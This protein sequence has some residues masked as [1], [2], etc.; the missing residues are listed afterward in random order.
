MCLPF[1]ARG[2]GS[3]G[4]SCFVFGDYIPSKLLALKPLVRSV[5]NDR[6]TNRTKADDTKNGKTQY[7]EKF[8]SSSEFS[9]RSFHLT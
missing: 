2:R 5:P 7:L 3:T 9:F 6:W 8:S 1:P 4:K